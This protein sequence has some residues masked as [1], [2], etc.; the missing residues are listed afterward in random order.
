MKAR[1]G[2]FLGQSPNH[3]EGVY[4][5]VMADTK[6]IVHT[7]NVIFHDQD[8]RDPSDMPEQLT[9]DVRTNEPTAKLDSCTGCRDLFR[10]STEPDLAYPARPSSGKTVPART[11]NVNYPVNAIVLTGDLSHTSHQ[12]H[13]DRATAIHG[14]SVAEALTMSYRKKDQMVKYGKA[15]LKYDL[16]K[17]YIK[18]ADPASHVLHTQA[19]DTMPLKPVKTHVDGIG[20]ERVS[21]SFFSKDAQTAVQVRADQDPLLQGDNWVVDIDFGAGSQQFAVTPNFE[22]HA[23]TVYK[24]FELTTKDTAFLT[25]RDLKA[26]YSHER[27][28]DILAAIATEYGEFDKRAIWKLTPLPEGAKLHSMMLLIKQKLRP[29]GTEEKIKARAV[30]MGNTFRPDIDYDSNSFAPC[31]SLCTARCMALDAVQHKKCLKSCDVKQAFTFGEPDRRTFIRIPPG[32]E[33]CY[34]KDGNPLVC[35][36]VKNVYG[37]PVG[38]VRWHVEIHNG[39]IGDGFVQSTTDQ[40]LYTKGCLNVLIYS[41]D[42]MSTFDDTPA[43]HTLYANFIKM[44]TSKFE[45]G[46]DGFQDCENF[47]GM[48]FTWSSDRTM[49][50]ISQPQK[51]LELLQSANMETCRPAFTPGT[52]NVLV[53]LLDCPEPHDTEQIAHMK[54]MPY[55]ARIGLLLWLAR[56][57]RPD[58]AYQVNALARVAHNPGRTHWDATS[59]LIRYVANTRKHG[60]VY[61]RDASASIEPGSWKPVLWSDATW[62][63]DYGHAFDNYRSTTGWLS[64]LS[65]NSV[66][67]TSHRQP[68]V[69]QSSAES[70]WYAAND[71]AKEAA[72]IRRVL[73]DLNN[74]I[75]GPITLMCDNQ[76]AIRQ[77]VTTVDLKNSRHIGLKQH[78]LRQQCNEHK[79]KLEY[80]PTTDQLA[81]ILTKC[82]PTAQNEKL[83]SALGVEDVAFVK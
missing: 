54:K 29:D 50:H 36:I 15:D 65:G 17:G 11:A 51:T 69:A 59:H 16:S 41:D 64:T 44:M 80:V 71:A 81:D 43:G 82:L 27:K 10:D 34:D 72:Y 55:R 45:L 5:V 46:D 6:R 56:N 67:W 32:K 58:I 68:V 48:H 42:C 23:P 1:K 35:E 26:I 21:A 53:S 74:K 47:I 63:P 12:P 3:A 4:A 79:L 14:K 7:M 39:M 28:T 49:L 83:R 19:F 30:L 52:P 57:T 13:I 78:Y 20:E 61:K 37:S 8:M 40:C 22:P 75:Y 62:A 77:T 18:F 66:S 38:P 9:F 76:S 33:L 2:Y 24:T 60:L 25:H 73:V 70:E 31:A